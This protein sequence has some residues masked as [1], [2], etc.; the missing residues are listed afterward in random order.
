MI[1]A[2]FVLLFLSTTCFGVEL[3]PP[4]VRSYYDLALWSHRLILVIPEKTVFHM[5]ED[6]QL[7]VDELVIEGTLV[8]NGFQL[9]VDTF[10]LTFGAQ[11][12]IQAFLAPAKQ[13]GRGLKGPDG[14]TSTAVGGR[15]GNGEDGKRGGKGADGVQNP[16][17][18]VIHAVE[19]FGVPSIDAAGQ[20]GGKGGRGGPGGTGGQGGK[21]KNAYSNC[22]GVRDHGGRGGGGGQGGRGGQGG[23]GG[24]GG[25]PVPVILITGIDLNNFSK[26]VSGPGKPGGAGKH[27]DPGGPGPGGAGGEPASKSC[28]GF[29]LT[30]T[31][32]ADRGPGGAGGPEQAGNL[33][34]G[35]EGQKALPIDSENEFLKL[36][37]ENKSPLVYSMTDFNKQRLAVAQSWFFFH[38]SRSFYILFNETL[39]QVQETATPK[40]LDDSTADLLSSLLSS[41]ND[42][43]L[44]LLIYAWEEHFV[45]IIRKMKGEDDGGLKRNSLQAA[46][47]ILEFLKE[48]HG[49][50]ANNRP[51]LSQLLNS[52]KSK[53]ETQFKTSLE[54]AIYACRQYVEDIRA[55]KYT[56][57]RVSLYYTIPVCMGEPDFEVPG[58]FDKEIPLF[59][60]RKPSLPSEWVSYVEEVAL[61]PKGRAKS[62][63]DF[64]FHDWFFPKAFARNFSV[65]PDESEN[66]SMEN[67]KRVVPQRKWLVEGQGVL[68]G[69]PAL[70]TK[71]NINEIRTSLIRL[72]RSLEAL[73]GN[74]GKK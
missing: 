64:P 73:D 61:L 23:V 67:L 1:R 27:G 22:G 3:A 60:V 2:I 48:L 12:K 69:Y 31:V 45:K 4:P 20:Q 55:E 57:N 21:G 16:G 32:S 72:G 54:S 33:G 29:L 18:I 35:S 41:V 34:D 10:K 9:N 50:E 24:Q 43:R 5:R 59:E 52:L 66:H 53:A 7:T 38:W 25:R 6:T 37:D 36:F 26:I 71:L 14:L 39:S 62:R 42:E 46:E 47:D 30:Y 74:G 28:G 44:R 68:K 58:N 11:G 70:K 17:A 63:F 49:D 40:T 8:T 65:Q 15:G 56:A 13:G 19:V 51:K